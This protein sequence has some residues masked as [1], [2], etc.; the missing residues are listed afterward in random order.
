MVVKKKKETIL[1]VYRMVTGHF[2]TKMVSL[3]VMVVIL[4]VKWMVSGL[5]T[6]QMVIVYSVV[7]TMKD[8]F[9]MTSTGDQKNFTLE[10]KN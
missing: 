3:S 4:M 7:G 9:Y 1:E 5:N 8:Y 10:L 2:G 6:Q